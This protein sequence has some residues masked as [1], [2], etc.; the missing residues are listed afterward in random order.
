MEIRRST[1]FFTLLVSLFGCRQDDKKPNVIIFFTDDQGYA[2]LGCYGATGFET[3]NLDA[4][5][6]SGIRFTSL[7]A[8][9]T[10]CTPSRA[11]LLTGLYPKRTNLH[12]AVIFPYS[13]HGLPPESYTLAEL[14]EDNGYS[15]ACIGKWHL[16]HQPEFMPNRQGFDYFYGVPYSNDMD[17]HYY[18]HNNFQSPPLPVYRNES[19]IEEGPDQRYLT[20]R[21]TEESIQLIKNRGDEPFFIYLA[22]NMPHTPLHVSEQFEGKSKMGLYGDVIMELDWSMGEIIRTLKEEHIYENTIVVF[23][24]DNGPIS[25]RSAR[26]LRGTKATTWE[27]GQRVPG[28]I[29]WPQEIPANKVSDEMVTLMDLFPT[30]VDILEDTDSEKRSFDGISLLQLLRSPE[31]TKLES[32]PFL[33]YAR[34]GQPEAIREGEWKLHVQKSRGWHQD[35][36]AFSPQL[37][38]LG[39][40][41]GEQNNVINEHPDIFKQM[42]DDLENEDQSIQ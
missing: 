36:I 32:R 4:L 8:P 11:G 14:F 10:V 2:D 31:K 9:A 1:V 38:Q 35:S 40:D 19:I 12:E 29:A 3:P 7:Y 5:A 39:I 22:H 27:G 15:T 37:Y 6:E 20:K 23:S 30:F 17:G 13:T 24:S 28:L 21:Y 18:R 42:Q 26:P 41:M 34:N 33:Y 25:N 16:G